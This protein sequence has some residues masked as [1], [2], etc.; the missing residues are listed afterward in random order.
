MDRT[1]KEEMQAQL[2]TDVEIGMSFEKDSW[3]DHYWRGKVNADEKMIE[4]LDRYIERRVSEIAQ[5]EKT[6]R[7]CKRGD[8]HCKQIGCDCFRRERVM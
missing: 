8:P 3:E 6:M 4:V 2:R 1:L 7:K 5:G